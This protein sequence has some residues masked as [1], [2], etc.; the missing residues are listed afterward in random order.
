VEI[1]ADSLVGA[2]SV[3]RKKVEPRS[4]VAGNPAVQVKGDITELACFAG[5]F[6]HAYSWLEEQRTP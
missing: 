1:G 3:V 5:I 4:V 6:P 2:A